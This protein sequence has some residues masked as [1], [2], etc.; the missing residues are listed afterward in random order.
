MVPVRSTHHRRTEQAHDDIAVLRQALSGL[1]K[2]DKLPNLLKNITL[3][4]DTHGELIV[5]QY[6]LLLN[7]VAGGKVLEPQPMTAVN[8]SWRKTY[9]VAQQT[10]M[11]PDNAG[12]EEIHRFQNEVM[13]KKLKA[14]KEFA[15]DMGTYGNETD[16]YDP[17][18]KEDW[19][20]DKYHY[21]QSVKK[22]YDPEDV[23]WCWRCVGN[24]AWAEI[25]G[26]AVY[27]PLCQTN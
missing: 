15:P 17:D 16:P 18:W 14:L 10:D 21:L 23:F 7:L 26:G 4:H 25:T 27:G 19:W 8:P 24:D 22:K 11:W 3:D 20:G 13:D 2:K 1:Q 5:S 6:A 12:H 9:L